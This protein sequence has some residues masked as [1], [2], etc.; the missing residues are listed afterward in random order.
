MNFTTVLS[1]CMYYTHNFNARK[2]RKN[3][4]RVV[5]IC[6]IDPAKDSVRDCIFIIKFYIG[7]KLI[8]WGKLPFKLK[9]KVISKC[10]KR[11]RYLLDFLKFEWRHFALEKVGIFH[12]MKSFFN[13]IHFQIL[14]RIFLRFEIRF[15]IENGQKIKN[16][17]H[18]TYAYLKC[19]QH[20]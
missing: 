4:N 11:C 6:F 9:R 10:S 16:E 17:L 14:C 13:P 2:Q 18:I 8:V 20:Y 15:D 7:I 5:Q 12:I 3:C 19:H 1:F